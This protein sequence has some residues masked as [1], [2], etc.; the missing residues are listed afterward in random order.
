M[1]GVRTTGL[2]EG[3]VQQSVLIALE[4]A[5]K[6]LAE[7]SHWLRSFVVIPSDRQHRYMNPDRFTSLLLPSPS[8]VL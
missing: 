2:R 5:R 8:S 3:M 4:K 7:R 1:R 6:E